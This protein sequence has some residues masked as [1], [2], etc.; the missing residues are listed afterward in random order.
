M[1]GERKAP[2]K[3]GAVGSRVLEPEGFCHDL[4]DAPVIQ[5]AF[6]SSIFYMAQQKKYVYCQKTKGDE[7]KTVRVKK[8]H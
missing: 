4:P 7:R 1:Q 2:S 5:K 3:P 8:S 6:E